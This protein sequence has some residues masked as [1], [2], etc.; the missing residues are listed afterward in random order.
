MNEATLE[1]VRQWAKNA[2][3]DILHNVIRIVEMR[4][5]TRED[6]FARGD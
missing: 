2:E 1:V 3:G 5:Q 4:R 6:L